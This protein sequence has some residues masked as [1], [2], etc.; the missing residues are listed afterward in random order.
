MRGHRNAE[1]ITFAVVGHNEGEYLARSIGQ[2]AAAARDGDRLLFVDGQS[3]DGSADLAASLGAEVV[4]APL[5]KGRAVAAALA[6]CEPPYIRLID[7]DI[8]HPA[9]H[10]PD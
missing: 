3:T 8:E 9:R 4:E 2:A 5:G 10:V 1:P 6:R 7:G